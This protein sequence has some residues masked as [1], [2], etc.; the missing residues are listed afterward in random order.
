VKAPLRGYLILLG[1]QLATGAAAIFARYAL[2]H[3][4][5]IAASALRL[6][7]GAAAIAI[8]LRLTKFGE[9]VERKDEVL[10]AGAGVALAFHFGTWITSLLYTTVAVSTLLVS[11]SPAFTALYDALILKKPTPLSFW[12][13]LLVAV[14][15]VA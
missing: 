7:I 10:L 1:A 11:T 14:G 13:A 8:Y 15:G 12:A 4:G 3:C 9:K 2:H 6:T 5:P